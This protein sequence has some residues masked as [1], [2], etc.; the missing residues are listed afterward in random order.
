MK[1]ENV[2]NKL[3]VLTTHFSEGV[4][5]SHI[6]NKSPNS[7]NGLFDLIDAADK[8]KTLLQNG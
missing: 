3:K 5:T 7:N 8:E 1:G 6:E 4:I 2:S